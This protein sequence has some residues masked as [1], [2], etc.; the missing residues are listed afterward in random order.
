MLNDFNRNL[1]PFNHL[2]LCTIR[3]DHVHVYSL[4]HQ[5]VE[6]LSGTVNRLNKDQHWWQKS[7]KGKYVRL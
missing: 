7:L 5:L 1:V 6:E 3:M 4:I 2:L